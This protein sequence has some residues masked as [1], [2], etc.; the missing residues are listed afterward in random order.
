LR[1]IAIMITAQTYDQLTGVF[2]EVFEDQSIIPTPEMRAGEVSEWD[3]VDHINLIVAF[4]SR[5]KIKFNTT[6]LESLRNVDGLV[7]LIEAKVATT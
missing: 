4:G 6:E 5:F 1:T 2:H 3:S 7:A